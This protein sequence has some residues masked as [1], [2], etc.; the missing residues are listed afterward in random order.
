MCEIEKSNPGL[1]GVLP[2]DY[3][4]P[5]LDKVMLG[6]LT[7]FVSGI[8]M[9]EPSDNPR[10]DVGPRIG[11]H[12]S[13]KVAKVQRRRGDGPTPRLSVNHNNNATSPGEWNGQV[14]LRSCHRRRDARQ[15]PRR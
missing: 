12:H 8:G 3:N 1:K 4:R 10:S 5:A 14:A 11:F 9:G 7:D 6:E 13:A 2:K 15:R